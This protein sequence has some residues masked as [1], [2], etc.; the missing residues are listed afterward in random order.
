[1]NQICE[2]GAL[3]WPLGGAHD[4]AAGEPQVLGS[5]QKKVYHPQR[6]AET[7]HRLGPALPLPRPHQ[8]QRALHQV[9]FHTPARSHRL[10]RLGFLHP[11][12]FCCLF[13]RSI[14]IGTDSCN[15]NSE[16]CFILK[17]WVYKK[18][19]KSIRDYC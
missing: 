5:F 18:K 17:V 6:Q 3:F 8:W 1:M 2:V 11:R 14:Q 7:E 16:F 4:P 9:Y 15:L 12:V 19:Y 10:T 13:L